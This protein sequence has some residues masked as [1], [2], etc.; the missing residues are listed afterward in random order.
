MIHIPCLPGK[1]ALALAL[2]VREQEQALVV[3]PDHRRDPAAPEHP[4][5]LE[6]I[7]KFDEPTSIGRGDLRG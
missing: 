4:R 1:K 5:V 3:G 2:A 7:K 6:A